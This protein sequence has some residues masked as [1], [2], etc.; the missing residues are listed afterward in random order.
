MLLNVACFLML[1]RYQILNVNWCR[2]GLYSERLNTLLSLS[3]SAYPCVLIPND[4]LQSSLIWCPHSRLQK[5]QLLENSGNLNCFTL[6]P[7]RCHEHNSFLPSLPCIPCSAVPVNKPAS[8]ITINVVTTRSRKGTTVPQ[9]KPWRGI[10]KRN[11]RRLPNKSK[12]D[13]YKNWFLAP[14]NRL[15]A[16]AN[17]VQGHN[18]GDT[19]SSRGTRGERRSNKTDS[20]RITRAGWR[21][22]KKKAPVSHE[23]AG[24][25]SSSYALG[26]V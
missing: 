14:N 11:N 10:R 18:R 21:S 25:I 9:M 12:M 2:Y 19:P 1:S 24:M 16:P 17:R 4:K 23:Q 15:P 6:I 8:P 20:G 22:S 13:L 3:Q 5:V 7:L 26:K